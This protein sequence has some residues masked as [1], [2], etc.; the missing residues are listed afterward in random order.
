MRSIM[1]AL[2]KAGTTLD[3]YWPLGS[4]INV[5]PPAIA[6]VFAAMKLPTY[7]RCNNLTVIKYSL[8]VDKQAVCVGVPVFESWYSK[9]V[10]ST[11]NIPYTS[12]LEVL[13][14][15]AMVI[16]G[17]NDYDKRF[18]LANSWG[19]EYGNKGFI[20][21]PYEYFLNNWWELS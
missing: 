14:G 16:C 2:N 5:E 20:T 3:E 21:L 9:D 4:P 19:I 7:E 6:Q 17:Y 13:G 1:S 11:G 8:A 15:H 12:N 10:I 18:I